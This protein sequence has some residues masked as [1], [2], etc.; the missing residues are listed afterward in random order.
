MLST[1]NLG[2]LPDV[3]NLIRIMQSLATLDAI[4]CE[5][6]EYRYFSFDNDWSPGEKLGSMQN[7]Q[8]DEIVAAFS[9]SGCWL[10]GIAHEAE[11]RRAKIRD[12]LFEGV[13]PEFIKYVSEPAFDIVYASFCIWR[14]TIDITWQRTP[15]SLPSVDFDGS[16]WLLKYLDGSPQSYC[17]W[18][19]VYYE[20]EVSLSAARLVF[21]HHPIDTS[22][23]NEFH[24]SRDLSEICD[25]LKKIGYPFQ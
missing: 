23:L 8:G 10:M 21:D 17:A 7:G 4:L 1:T 12:R 20:L 6:W 24:C 14:R 3:P 13:P 2:A 25:D 5:D 19:R 11:I 9:T 15:L 16:P 18:A 22:L